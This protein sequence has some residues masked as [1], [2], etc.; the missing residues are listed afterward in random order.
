VSKKKDKKGKKVKSAKTGKTGRPLKESTQER[1][2]KILGFTKKAVSNTELAEKLG[3]TTAKSQ[4]YARPMVA[5]G[6][7]IMKKDPDTA[8][9][10]YQAK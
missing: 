7:L 3:V 4:A 5:E 10:T 1:R 6:L 2:K 8:R 9:V